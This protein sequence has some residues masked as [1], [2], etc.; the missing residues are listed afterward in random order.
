MIPCR[1]GE[2][3]DAIGRFIL[4]PMCSEGSG[5]WGDGE[6]IHK[7]TRVYPG[8]GPSRGG[9]SPTPACLVCI[10]SQGITMSSPLALG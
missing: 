7:D 2:Q 3:T 4:G 1:R 8:S 10:I 6:E 9:N 5:G